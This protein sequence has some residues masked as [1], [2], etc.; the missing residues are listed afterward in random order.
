MGELFETLREAVWAEL[1][2]PARPREITAVRRNLQRA[3][4]DRLETLLLQESLP[5]IG[6]ETTIPPDARSLARAE[7]EALRRRL[8]TAEGAADGLSRETRAHLAESR[9]RAERALETSLTL[10]AGG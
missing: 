6:G 2:R 5:G 9:A 4:L 10:P 8:A 1:E 3:H 7:L